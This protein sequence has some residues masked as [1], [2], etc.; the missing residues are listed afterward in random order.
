MDGSQL[1]TLLPFSFFTGGLRWVLSVLRQVW[2]GSC[3]QVG[4]VVTSHSPQHERSSV[5][6]F[7]SLPFAPAHQSFWLPLLLVCEEVS[8]VSGFVACSS[9]CSA[10]W[11]L[12]SN[13]S[14]VSHLSFCVF[15]IGLEGCQHQ[16]TKGVPG[17]ERDLVSGRVDVCEDGTTS[18]HGCGLSKAVVTCWVSVLDT[19]SRVGSGLGSVYSF[20]LSDI[21]FHISW[22]S[23]VFYYDSKSSTF[24]PIT[25]SVFHCMAE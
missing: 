23:C 15:W 14:L 12:H 16:C 2:V 22:M 4:A 3:L 18:G 8:C 20:V 1:L 21:Q 11:L 25:Y 9:I 10:L 5:Y 6:I 7:E 19:W 24:L 13:S 17:W